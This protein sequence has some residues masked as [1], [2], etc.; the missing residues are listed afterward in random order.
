MYQ[1][2][3][4]SERWSIG[5]FR[6]EWNSLDKFQSKS[7]GVRSFCWVGP[8]IPKWHVNITTK[9]WNS[10][11]IWILHGVVDPTTVTLIRLILLDHRLLYHQLT[12]KVLL[13]FDALLCSLAQIVTWIV[14]VAIIPC[15]QKLLKVHFVLAWEVS[16]WFK[17]TF[18]FRWAL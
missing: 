6:S 15:R 4:I 7:L 10:S 12:Q 14:L 18:W 8:L 13:L 9:S 1:H 5:C 3:L 11:R 2:K 16:W 17:I